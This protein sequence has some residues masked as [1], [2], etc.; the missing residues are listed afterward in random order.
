[1]KREK[2]HGRLV[3]LQKQWKSRRQNKLENASWM[4]P[5][6]S[7]ASKSYK[8]SYNVT[9]SSKVS[10]HHKHMRLIRS[11]SQAIKKGL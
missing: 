4:E 6:N 11:H 2:S 10:G 9:N 8:S 1:M 7:K 3:N 5:V